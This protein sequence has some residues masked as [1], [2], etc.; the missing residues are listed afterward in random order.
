MND[1]MPVV[2]FNNRANAE[3]IARRLAEVGIPAEVHDEL[4]LQKLWF[5]SK[6]NAGARVEVPAE[7]F[8]QACRRLSDWDE[9]EGALRNAIRC[10][11]CRSLRVEYPQFTR[12]SFIPNLVMGFLAAVG[13]VEKQY[14]CYDCHFTWPKEGAKAPLHQEH[15][16]PYFFIQGVEQTRLQA[17]A[18][19]DKAA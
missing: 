4:G 12:K 13:Q 16:A 9:T 2:I 19:R 7:K 14:Y 11:E 10:P 3:P 15:G 5:A 18:E 6:E 17:R 1:D 8:E